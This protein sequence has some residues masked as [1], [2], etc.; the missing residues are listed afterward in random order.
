[1]PDRTCYTKLDPSLRIQ[2]I[3]VNSNF[4][5]QSSPDIQKKLKQAEDALKPHKEIL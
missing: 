1:M 3:I 5:S 2:I 4:I